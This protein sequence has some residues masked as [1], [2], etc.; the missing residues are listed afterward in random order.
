MQIIVHSIQLEHHH[1]WRSAY[2]GLQPFDLTWFISHEPFRLRPATLFPSLVKI[3][4]SN[5]ELHRPHLID[6]LMRHL[7]CPIC[8]NQQWNLHLTPQKILPHGILELIQIIIHQRRGLIRIDHA[9]LAHIEWL[10]A[11]P[12]AIETSTGLVGWIGSIFAASGLVLVY[13]FVHMLV[14]IYFYNL[15]RDFGN[16]ITFSWWQVCTLGYEF[17]RVLFFKHLII[18]EGIFA[19]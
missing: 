14:V 16:V 18:R 3:V 17:L 10:H 4:L 6:I 19:Y 1:V 5:P 11:L 15:A 12:M 13:Q 9:L 8:L 7:L 2:P